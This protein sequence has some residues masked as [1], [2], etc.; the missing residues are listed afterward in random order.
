MSQQ[1]NLDR[2]R[3]SNFVRE[4]W[5]H[6]DPD[7][8]FHRN[9]QALLAYEFVERWFLEEYNFLK[10]AQRFT[11]EGCWHATLLTGALDRHGCRFED[12]V[13]LTNLETAGMLA[14]ITPDNRLP[15]PRRMM[16]HISDLG[17]AKPYTQLI[18]LVQL[19]QE[20]EE[21]RLRF[22]DN[23][24]RER[25]W[26]KETV[27]ELDRYV[28]ALWKLG[29]NPAVRKEWHKVKTV[30]GMLAQLLDRWRQREAIIVKL[31][32]RGMD[33]PAPKKV[34]RKKRSPQG[35]GGN[36]LGHEHPWYKE[37]LN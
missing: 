27:P 3:T 6:E 9:S 15:A 10:P 37:P 22:L 21:A 34:R 25:A 8:F 7:G 11:I 35:R 18:R 32:E 17:Q 4:R 2:A 29:E 33:V 26:L 31:K 19:G 28:D 13:E 1:D 36:I 20:V 24:E 12:I 30:S 5:Y 14:E 23:P 16:M